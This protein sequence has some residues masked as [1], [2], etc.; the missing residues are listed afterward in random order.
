MPDPRKQTQFI[1]QLYLY[2]SQV[3]THTTAQA[4]MVTD[5][6]QSTGFLILKA[7]QKK[8][9]HGTLSEEPE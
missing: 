2:R 9:K 4:R 3:M 6:E 8:R 7:Q 5:V 1:E